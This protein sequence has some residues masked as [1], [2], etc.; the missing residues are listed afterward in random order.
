MLLCSMVSLVG[1]HAMLSYEPRQARK[2]ATVVADACAVEWL[3][4]ATTSGGKGRIY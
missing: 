2:G 1:P 3:A 4:R